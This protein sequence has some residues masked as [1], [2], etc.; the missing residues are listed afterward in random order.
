MS[1][2]INEQLKKQL[3]EVRST[4]TRPLS[5]GAGA[6]LLISQ[7]KD[8][9]AE[10][11]SLDTLLTEIGQTTNL[12]A[13]ELENL[14]NA[15]LDAADKYAKS[16]GSY[17]E[18][19]KEMYHAGYTNADQMSGLS[20]LA[21]AAGSMD[22]DTADSYLIASD[23]AYNLKGNIEALNEVLDGQTHIAGNTTVSMTD[24]A[25]ATSETA[26]LA[27]KSGIK[28]NELSALIATVASQTHE[29]GTETANALNTLFANLQDTSADSVRDALNSVNISMTEMADGS[30]KLKSPIALL[31]KL[32]DTFL[33]L[34]ENDTRRTD[35][36]SAI[37]GSEHADTLSALLNNWS[38]Y[39]EMLNLYESGMGSA[40]IAAEQSADSWEISLNR[41]S[42]TWT[43][44]MGTITD[45]GAFTTTID[46]LN[47][48]L[49]LLNKLGSAGTIGLGAGLFAS[50]KNA[51]RVKRNPS[52]RICL[53]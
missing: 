7:T 9:I 24:M 51:G 21:Q 40:A 12:T 16:A 34:D 33:Q 14:G 20:M 1:N 36:L 10:L 6:D 38:S 42:S 37:G 8:S 31:G 5:L 44:T 13:K 47:G 25:S 28:I 15:A 32:A 46:G 11:K 30:G 50:I 4:L 53:L 52:Y 23:A 26:E 2:S 19:V 35:L 22:S 3:E 48:I 49:S 29:S 39:G 18:S 45:S 41:L 43:E 27:A 17:L